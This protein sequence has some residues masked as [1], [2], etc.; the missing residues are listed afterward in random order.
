MGRDE[1]LIAAAKS[2][3]VAAARAA[4]DGSAHLECKDKEVRAGCVRAVP[5]P[6]A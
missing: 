1:D 6:Y 2:G 3:D 5:T 4:L